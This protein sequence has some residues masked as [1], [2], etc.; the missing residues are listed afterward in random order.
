[1]CHA[2]GSRIE[3]VLGDAKAWADLGRDHGAGLTE[4]EVRYL[5]DHEWA[6]QPD[7]ILWRRT[8]LGQHMTPAER[9]A[10]LAAPLAVAS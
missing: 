10:F 5:V 8:K 7:D 2:Y 1:M 6:R 4:R 9:D 3:A